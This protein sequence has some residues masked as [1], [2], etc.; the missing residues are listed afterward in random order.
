L[1]P[2]AKPVWRKTEN[3]MQEVILFILQK[4]NSPIGEPLGDKRDVVALLLHS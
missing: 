3:L 4:R 1:C 2:R